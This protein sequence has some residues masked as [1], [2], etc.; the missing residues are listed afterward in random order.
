MIPKIIHYCWF[1]GN[2]LP[3][4]EKKCIDSWKE[5]C[6]DYQIIEWN[7]NNYDLDKGPYIKEAY[8]AKKWAFVSDYA[9]L[10]IIYTYGGIYL[11]TDVELLKNLDDVL[12]CHC[13][14]TTEKLGLINTGLGFGAEKGN[15]NL[16]QMLKRYDNIHFKLGNNLYDTLPC[17]YRN[18]APFIEMG[19][20]ALDQIQVIND[21]VIYPPEYF[22]PMD[23]E[24]KKVNITAKTISFHH[25]NASWITDEE[26]QFML[27]IDEY[28]RKHNIISSFF[29]KNIYEYKMYY[30]KGSLFSLLE[31]IWNK[32]KKKII[33]RF[34]SI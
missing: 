7:E 6:P 22:S 25:Y 13:F 10:D 32:I 18:T 28:K 29:Y 5:K 24:S 20:Q 14:L 23:Y 33:R 9:R 2:E 21:A 30:G 8:D 16:E 15:V 4:L 31:F 1:G 27:S 11:D 3:S 34:K 17:T 12:D 19:F 26:K